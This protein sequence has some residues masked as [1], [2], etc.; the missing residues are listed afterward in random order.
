MRGYQKS[1][2]KG[3]YAAMALVATTALVTCF[4]L[5]LLFSGV[6]RS[7]EGQARAQVMVDYAQ[8]Q[9]A[10]LRALVA[11]LPARAM[12]AMRDGSALSPYDC[13][14]ESIFD[15]AIRLAGADIMVDQTTLEKFGIDGLIPANP[16]DEQ[17]SAASVISSLSGA[18]DFVDSGSEIS[19]GLLLNPQFRDRLPDPLSASVSV[20]SRDSAYPVISDEKQ[21]APSWATHALLPVQ[22]W[23]RYNLIPYPRIRFGYAEPG[24]PFLAK[25]NWWAFSVTFGGGIKAIPIRPERRNYIISLYEIPTQLPISSD[26]FLAIGKHA[27]GSD[28]SNVEIAGSIYGGKLSTS[29]GFALPFG[30]ISARRGMDLGAGTTVDGAAVANSDRNLGTREAFFALGERDFQRASLSSDSGR[31]AFVP[32]N[33]GYPFFMYD[34]LDESNAISP[35]GWEHYSRGALRCGMRLMITRVASA[36]DQTP[37]R[38][39][40]SYSVGNGRAEA[41]LDRLSNWPS[42]DSPEGALLPFQTEHTETGRKALVLHLERLPGWLASL[43]GD[44][45]EVNN[46]LVINPVPAADANMKTPEYPSVETDMAL[47]LR[48]SRD[49]SA[50]RKGFSLVTNLRLYLAD[51]FN[52]VATNPP[53]GSGLP[54]GEPFYPP[55]SLFA[56]EKRYGTTLKVRPVEYHGQI[57]SL[58]RGESTPIHPLD[59][60]AGTYEVV[61]PSLITAELRPARSPAELPPISLMHW[62]IVIDEI[63]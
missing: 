57:T 41:I 62:L 7:H 32:I 23:P 15:E 36:S 63:F 11:V 39:E 47:V 13:S 3:G 46:S 44:G 52:L 17:L 25:R 9:D 55:V 45:P 14:W 40:L 61:N 2:K 42:D 1:A 8:K 12:A 33:P 30:S 34:A 10:L 51:H 19:T 38:L 27:D 50:Y 54:A 49:L 59:F 6:M 28:W 60:R 20:M 29:T 35:T 56:P 37:T 18:P 48:H 43:G 58:A 22:D 16:G 5:V 26:A 53:P 4:S 24:T 31:V 21:L